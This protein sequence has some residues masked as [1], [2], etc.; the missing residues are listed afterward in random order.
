M[1]F[2][3][4]AKATAGHFP[5]KNCSISS[6]SLCTSPVP[7]R[8]ISIDDKGW[9]PVTRYNALSFDNAIAE[10]AKEGSVTIHFGGDPRA[11]NLLPI[12]PGWNCI[13]RMYQPGPEIP[14]GRWTF[15]T[16]KPVE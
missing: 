8:S 6:S 5:Q 12:V 2:T 10:V 14:K 7:V 11:E 15:P 9:I 3:C 16:A 4:V 13:V 1:P